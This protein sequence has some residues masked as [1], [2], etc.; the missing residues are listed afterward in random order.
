MIADDAFSVESFRE[1]VLGG[2]GDD[3]RGRHVCAYLWVELSMQGEWGRVVV[4]L[5][6]R[7]GGVVLWRWWFMVM[8]VQG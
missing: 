6:T 7:S 5:C 8:C 1:W 3:E 2:G 4:D